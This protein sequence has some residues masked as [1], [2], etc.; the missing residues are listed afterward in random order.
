MESKIS[1]KGLK[2]GCLYCIVFDYYVILE[3]ILFIL[4]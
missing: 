2:G 4:N 1:N 3:I